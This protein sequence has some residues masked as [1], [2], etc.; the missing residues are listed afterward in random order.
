MG[1]SWGQT[2]TGGPCLEATAILQMRTA[3]IMTQEDGG[4][5]KEAIDSGVVRAQGEGGTN[6]TQG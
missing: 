2:E 1:G 6:D 3:K 4:K 5:D